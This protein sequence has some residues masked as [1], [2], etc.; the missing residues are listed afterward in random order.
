[1]WIKIHLSDRQASSNKSLYFL[2]NEFKLVEKLR[3]YL[4]QVRGKTGRRLRFE[5]NKDFVNSEVKNLVLDNEM[6]EFSAPF[7]LQQNGEIEREN[8]S[9]VESAR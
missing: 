2:K 6:Q 9:L 8:M 1:M 4:I 5:N 3:S 7:I